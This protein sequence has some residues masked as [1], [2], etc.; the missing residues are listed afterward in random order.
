MDQTEIPGNE[1]DAL[2]WINDMRFGIANAL[3]IS[4]SASVKIYQVDSCADNT[5]CTQVFPG[6]RRHLAGMRYSRVYVD[7]KN[8]MAAVS[9][10][11]M[12]MSTSS[13]LYASDGVFAN[14][15]VKGM[16]VDHCNAE[17]QNVINDYRSQ[18]TINSINQDPSDS[19][20]VAISL[21]VS[22]IFAL[23]SF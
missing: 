16:K 3:G 8:F 4:A 23:F 14:K 18:S 17:V 9:F 19:S 15:I 20:A 2:T 7:I 12:I 21:M 22:M 5:G 13:A 10:Q 11:E 1:R 6:G